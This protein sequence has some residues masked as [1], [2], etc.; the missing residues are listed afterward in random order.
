MNG[1]LL[2]LLACLLRFL[3][4]WDPHAVWDSCIIKAS[5]PGDPDPIARH[6]L[7]DITDEDRAKWRASRPDRLGERNPSA[8]S[9]SPEVGYCVR[10]NSGCWYDAKPAPGLRRAGKDGA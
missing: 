10:V 3:C 4:S 1:R 2:A 7:D 5:V 6:L 9:I 8:I